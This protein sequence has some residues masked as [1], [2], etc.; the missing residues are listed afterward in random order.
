MTTTKLFSLAFL[1]M[2]AGFVVCR[3]IPALQ[4]YFLYRGKRLVICPETARTETVDVAARTAAANSFLGWTALRLD[5]CSRWP[6]RQDCGQEC[7][8]QI[9]AESANCLPW[10]IV[11]SWYFGQRCVFCGKRFSVLRH[12]DHVPALLREDG[13]TFEWNQILP[14]Q[15]PQIFSTAK[16]VCW[17]CHIAETFRRMSI[18]IEWQPGGLPRA[19]G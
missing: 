4:T 5:R 11:S 8:K 3:V 12:F 1:V 18:S 14:Q 19:Q 10:N 17:N 13:A 15:L 9:T 7:I 2:I 6:E 16:P